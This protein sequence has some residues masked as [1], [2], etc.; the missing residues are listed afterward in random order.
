MAGCGGGGDDSASNGAYGG[1]GTGGSSGHG[2]TGGG[3]GAAGTGGSAGTSGT[4]GTGQ[5][6]GT[7]NDN[8]GS[9]TPADCDDTNKQVHPGATEVC[10]GI[11]DNCNGQKDEGVSQAYYADNDGDSWGAD[12]PATNVQAC[13][14][15][16]GYVAKAGDCNDAAWAI[17]PDQVEIWGNGIDENCDGVADKCMVGQTSCDGNN[18][19]TCDSSGAWGP[20]VSCGLL[21]C[22]NGYG[23]VTCT[24]MEASCVGN[25]AHRCAGD[26][27]GWV[28][29][30]CDPVVGSTCDA[31]TCTGP[32]SPDLLGRTYIG[33]DYYP[34]VTINAYIAELGGFDGFHYAVA[35][36][37]TTSDAANLTITQGAATVA[38]ATVAPGSAQ[39][40]ALPW[41]DLRTATATTMTPSGAYRLRS[42][43]P[44]TV[45]QFN[46]LEYTSAGNG[47]YSN[48][49][50]ILIP[51]TAWGK[52]YMVASRNTW[53]W[54]GFDVPG[55]Y[56]VVAS[57]D[58]T[59][60]NLTP[61]GT[62]GSLRPGAGLSSNQGALTLNRGD[63][64]QVLSGNSASDDLTGTIVEADK[65][66]EVL[67]GHSCTFV[68]ADVGYCDHLEESMF[69]INTLAKE[70][71]VSPPSLPTMTQPK[72]FFV[73]VIATEPGTTA[74][75]DP[76]VSG[77]ITLANAGDYVE[78]D[79]SQSFQIL[80][81]ARVLVSQYMKGQDAG[82]GSGDPAMA[83]AVTS[84]QFRKDYL[85]HS[86]VNYDYNYVNVIAPVGASVTLDGAPVGGFEPVSASGYAVARVLFGNTGDGNHR[87][88][89]DQKVGITVYGYGQYTSYWYPGGL[90]LTELQ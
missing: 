5:P 82:G 39:V 59:T 13:S 78:L 84:S 10:N 76:A 74:Q 9:K 15:P 54:N 89:A 87:I 52:K 34:T 7:D 40:I 58:G 47:S 6:P 20:A 67:A 16:S 65:P 86:P 75:F 80:A 71:I 8:D 1:Q 60:V 49:A 62:G 51:V 24:P 22:L 19:L 3:G 14:P 45:Y 70:Y 55:F 72:P 38:T 37:N 81:S 56:S 79:A 88:V 44:V 35:V 43:R 2:A 77:P 27:S 33:C 31:G 50:S 25:V 46:P 11:D 66:I 69:P 63:V 68:P 64:L 73:R 42:T 4:G 53:L 17:N 18:V 30:E 12:D 57:Q 32:C 85:F 90:N 29:T 28:D 41:T 36:S 83:L 26:G 48:D 21:S 23:C 61:S